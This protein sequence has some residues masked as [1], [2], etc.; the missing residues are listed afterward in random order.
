MTWGHYRLFRARC[1]SG[2]PAH[3]KKKTVK[4][5]LEHDERHGRRDDKGSY[6]N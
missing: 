3:G 5:S 1:F 2:L 6:E 4:E